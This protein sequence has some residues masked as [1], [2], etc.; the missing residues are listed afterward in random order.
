[1]R[2]IIYLFSLILLSSCS[3]LSKQFFLA[4]NP[5]AYYYS[6]L[7]VLNSEIYIR[8]NGI[9]K[10]YDKLAKN[11]VIP[12]YIEVLP[13]E[14]NIQVI[15]NINL[16]DE[17]FRYYVKDILPHLE[18]TILYQKYDR[19]KIYSRDE[20]TNFSYGLANMLYTVEETKGKVKILSIQD[21]KAYI[22]TP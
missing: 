4:K 22:K 8:K 10:F 14:N 6:I 9:N 16:N 17:E 12:D 11:D 19:N 15:G 1:M 13:R 3:F 2:K 7:D 18:K 21:D 20:F 5:G